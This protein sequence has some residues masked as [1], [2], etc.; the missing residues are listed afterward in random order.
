MTAS[1]IQEE[2]DQ[3]QALE[4]Q[5]ALINEL[6]KE[7]EM[8][9]ALEEERLMMDVEAVVGREEDVDKACDEYKKRNYDNMKGKL[10]KIKIPEHIA[11]WAVEASNGEWD[12]A[13]KKAYQRM[14][15]EEEEQKLR[16]PPATPCTSQSALPEPAATLPPP[17]VPRRRLRKK[18]WVE[19]E[20][21]CAQDAFIGAD[22][23]ETLHMNTQSLEYLAEE[24][25]KSEDPGQPAETG[26]RPYF[27]G[28][29]RSKT[30]IMGVDT[31]SNLDTP[32]DSNNPPDP[33]K[34][35]DA[36]KPLDSGKPSLSRSLTRESVQDK[37]RCEN[38]KANPRPDDTLK[39]VG[40]SISPTE[41]KHLFKET[42]DP[43]EEEEAD[44]SA[45][46]S[47]GRGNRRGKG[48]GR[49]R[50]KGRGK[51]RKPRAPSKA[52]DAKTAAKEKDAQP[53][54][55]AEDSAAAS[56]TAPKRR[57][58][59][60]GV[61]TKPAETIETKAKASRA[62]RS[63]KASS[64]GDGAASSSSAPKRG[65]VAHGTETEPT[66]A[67]ESAPTE[68]AE[69]AA[70]TGPRPTCKAKAKPKAK[71]APKA[72]V[73]EAKQ[74]ASRRSSAYHVARGGARGVGACR[75]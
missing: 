36:D 20:V 72:D 70:S 9:E 27:A 47:R 5:L 67:A 37:V 57:R 12:D 58:G 22:N 65:K 51:G 14:Q 55:A 21:P 7:Q 63:S 8:L 1:Q 66:E 34:T 53:E 39:T 10:L 40:Q 74:R 24:V 38:E 69:S 35:S 59:A 62:K 49:G 43:E 17:P 4:Q 13:F 50:G 54:T 44:P 42:A 73:S 61:D 2:I 15:E 32:S 52:A 45:L 16:R 28:K 11:T 56:S 71:A 75:G 19:P 29:P 41:Q 18:S 31:P 26:E 68:T 6:Q 25:G 60:R 64:S 30:L 46:P 48:R 3:L 33:D 23:T